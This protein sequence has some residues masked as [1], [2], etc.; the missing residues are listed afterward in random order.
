MPRSAK[1]LPIPFLMLVNCEP[2]NALVVV[3]CGLGVAEGPTAV[4]YVGGGCEGISWWGVCGD[5]SSSGNVTI[6]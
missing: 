6:G 2:T 4:L 1:P 5:G 3:W